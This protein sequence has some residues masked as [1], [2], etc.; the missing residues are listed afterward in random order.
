MDAPQ[1]PSETYTIRRYIHLKGI[2]DITGN[3]ILLV[4]IFVI[5]ISLWSSLSEAFR[6]ASVI[7]YLFLLAIMLL[8]FEER[9]VTKKK[10][11][12]V[13][14]SELV[15]YD[16]ELNIYIKY[17]ENLQNKNALVKDWNEKKKIEV[18]TMNR[19]IRSI[20]KTNTTK[21]SD[22][23]ENHKTSLSDYL[24]RFKEIIIKIKEAEVELEKNL[25]ESYMEFL[26]DKIDDLNNE[27]LSVIN[28]IYNI[29]EKTIENTT[30]IVI[31][32]RE[33]I[34][35]GV[36]REDY[37]FILN[38]YAQSIRGEVIKSEN[39]YIIVGSKISKLLY[40]SEKSINNK[41]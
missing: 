3:I 34:P 28:N 41:I 6:T 36:P 1:K 35:I 7:V 31:F 8:D 29:S 17:L 4:I 20:N 12:S 19:I 32:R 11:H 38:N 24:C 16:K 10:K 14:Q 25:E 15:E 2:D 37:E 26:C 39:G 30:K 18:N 22:E 23:I 21:V 5:L 33:G 27:K 40:E 9:E 13:I